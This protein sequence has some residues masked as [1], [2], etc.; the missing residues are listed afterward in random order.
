[1][2]TA[3][4]L[5]PFVCSCSESGISEL[6]MDVHVATSKAALSAL[7]RLEKLGKKL[8]PTLLKMLSSRECRGEGSSIV[9]A[10]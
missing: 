2:V 4:Q 1:M 6:E 7:Q 8:V 9:L 5:A 10:V 3:D